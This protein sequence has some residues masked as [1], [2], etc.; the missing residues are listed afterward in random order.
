MKPIV[1]KHPTIYSLQFLGSWEVPSRSLGG[2]WA[3]LE[4]SFGGLEAS[5]RVGDSSTEGCVMY[6]DETIT[7]L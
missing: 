1:V 7:F 4:A 2:P 6:T 5:P 3:V